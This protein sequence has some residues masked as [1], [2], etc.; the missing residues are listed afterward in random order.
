M[1][2][3]IHLARGARRLGVIALAVVVAPVL[4]V[5]GAVAAPAEVNT[6][7]TMVAGSDL[8]TSSSLAP[9]RL[10]G[11][12]AARTY[13]PAQLQSFERTG[14]DPAVLA[15]WTPERM[16]AAK[17]MDAPGD[18]VWVENTARAIATKTPTV[19]AKPHGPGVV[20][21]CLI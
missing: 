1:S 3:R 19:S 14:G 13:T 10:P 6:K 18:A 21:L 16:K 5:T 20:P 11:D 12:K 15:Y 7:P 8:A 4:T 9:V 2:G 17:P